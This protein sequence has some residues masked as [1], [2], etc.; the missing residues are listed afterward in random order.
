MNDVARLWSAG[1]ALG[2]S[3]ENSVV[4][5]ETRLLKMFIRSQRLK[6]STFLHDDKRNAVGQSPRLVRAL[7]EQDQAF[8]EKLLRQWHDFDERIALAI[9]QGS[10][11]QRAGLGLRQK[12]GD[13]KQHG[14]RRQHFHAPASNLFH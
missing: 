7:A 12:I 8:V 10:D 2:A 9:F 4:F 6:D 13:L 14:T 3:F 5:D 11:D 1:F